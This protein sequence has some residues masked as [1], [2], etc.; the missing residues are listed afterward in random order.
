MGIRVW[1]VSFS[2]V[3]SADDDVVENSFVFFLMLPLPLLLLLLPFS[4]AAQKG[5]L[6]LVLLLLQLLLHRFDD[7]DFLRNGENPRTVVERKK[8]TIIA[9]NV[10]R[11]R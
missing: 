10:I 2:F 5:M 3:S 8:A 6:V 4:I 7:D 1:V 11:W 9:E